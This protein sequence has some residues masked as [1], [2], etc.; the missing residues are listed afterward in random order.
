MK[1][2][3]NKDKKN[4]QN[5]KKKA[6]GTIHIIPVKKNVPIKDNNSTIFNFFKITSLHKSTSTTTIHE[7]R[8]TKLNDK[9]DKTESKKNYKLSKFDFYKSKKKNNNLFKKLTKNTEENENINKIDISKFILFNE[10]FSKEINNI[11][12]NNFIRSFK[13]YIDEKN[14][15]EIN[16]I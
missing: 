7:T 11:F 3:Q 10:N 15:N 16:K 14:K 5:T 1:K 2:N 13:R 9:K 8:Q 12:T 6:Q 4:P